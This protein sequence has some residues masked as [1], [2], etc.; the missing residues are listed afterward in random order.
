MPI[1]RRFKWR[2]LIASS[3]FTISIG[4]TLFI[5]REPMSTMTR[6]LFDDAREKWQQAGIVDYDLQYKMNGSD[7]HIEVRDSIVTVAMVDGRQPTSSNWGTYAMDGLFEIL[8]LEIDNQEEG[9]GPFA[10]GGSA[11]MR[12]RFNE[13]RGYIERYLR[14]GLGRNAVV[15]VEALTAVVP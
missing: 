13:E 10:G 11:L 7:Y 5:A 6:A 15:E 4:V 9:I 8:L 1:S 12:V 2:L 3:A 14:G